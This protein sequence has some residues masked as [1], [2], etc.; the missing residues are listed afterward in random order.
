[1]TAERGE[2][3]AKHAPPCNFDGSPELQPVS[4]RL[5]HD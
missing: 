3:K 1:M 2:A 5:C 4:H